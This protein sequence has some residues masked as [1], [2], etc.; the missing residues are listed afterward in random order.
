MAALPPLPVADAIA[1][2][3]VAAIAVAALLPTLCQHGVALCPCLGLSICCCCFAAGG[4]IYK[5]REREE[6]KESHK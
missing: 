6:S 4:Q 3:A 2:V 5:Y 1:A